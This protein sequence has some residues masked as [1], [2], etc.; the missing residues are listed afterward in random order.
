MSAASGRRAGPRRSDR[1]LDAAPPRAGPP[2]HPTHAPGRDDLSDRAAS[3]REPRPCRSQPPRRR[4][5]RLRTAP[6]R[7][8][9]SE[10]PLEM[11]VAARGVFD[12]TEGHEQVVFCHDPLTGLRAIIAIH[13]TALGPALGGTRFYPYADEATAL[14]DVL[15]TR[16]RHDVQGC[17]GRARPRRRQGRDSS[18]TRRQTRPR[19][20]SA[21]TAGSSS[22][23]AGATSPRAT[24][25]PTCPTW[26]SWPASAT[27]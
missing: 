7:E 18:A 11:P 13:S 15:Q 22:P 16:S 4:T 17:A 26:T 2:L 19:H 27:S 3:I 10:L 6:R 25:A 9:R 21:R 14:A 5:Q 12:Q 23:S 1:R 8:P 20:C 24:S